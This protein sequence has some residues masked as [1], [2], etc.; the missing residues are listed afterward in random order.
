MFTAGIEIYFGFV[1]GGLLLALGVGIVAG[2]YC[3]AQALWHELFCK[4]ALRRR[5]AQ[6]ERELQGAQ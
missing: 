3:F 2:C 1:A 4:A 6:L 5:I